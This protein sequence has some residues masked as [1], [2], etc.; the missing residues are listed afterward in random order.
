VRKDQW[1][2][3][4]GT[5]VVIVNLDD[6]AISLVPLVPLI[7]HPA[8]QAIPPKVEVVKNYLGRLVCGQRLVWMVEYC[9][10]VVSH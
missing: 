3:Y 9:K 2:G 8:N 7:P 5:D 10:S 1:Y 6:T 4:V